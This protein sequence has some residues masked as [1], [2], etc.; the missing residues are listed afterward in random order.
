MCVSPVSPGLGLGL[1]ALGLH[2]GQLAPLPAGTALAQALRTHCP[3]LRALDVGGCAATAEGD[4]KKNGASA[5]RPERTILLQPWAESSRLRIAV[6][7]S[8]ARA[9]A[10]SNSAVE[11]RVLWNQLPEFAND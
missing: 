10:L 11:C 5:V 8:L 3:Q 1:R 2:D 4:A 6:I 7:S 9:R